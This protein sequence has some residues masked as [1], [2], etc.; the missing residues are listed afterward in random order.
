MIDGPSC[1]PGAQ[2]QPTERASQL[3]ERDNAAL[4]T[5]TWGRIKDI[6]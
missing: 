5:L 4:F 1:F 2:V 3:E 6:Q